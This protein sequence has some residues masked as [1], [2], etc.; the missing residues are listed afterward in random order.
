MVDRFLDSMTREMGLLLDKAGRLAARLILILVVVAILC[1]VVF[2][3]F[4]IAS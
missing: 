1:A 3:V 2:V 4:L